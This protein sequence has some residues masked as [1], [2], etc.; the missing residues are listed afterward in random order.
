MA[1][2]V[3]QRRATLLPVAEHL[4]VILHQQ[5]VGAAATPVPVVAAIAA[6]VVAAVVAVTLVAAAAVAAADTVRQLA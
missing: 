3:L 6:V 1:P 2:T 5:A 4:R